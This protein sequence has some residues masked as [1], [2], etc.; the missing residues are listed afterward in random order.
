M[1]QVAAII[2]DGM[3]AVKIPAWG[4]LIY[5]LAEI[6][7]QAIEL[8]GNHLFTICAMV[9]VIFQSVIS[10]DFAYGVCEKIG[11]SVLISG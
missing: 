3:W 4:A 11:G 2:H 1:T 7:N 9:F 10:L 6:S 8:V 5:L